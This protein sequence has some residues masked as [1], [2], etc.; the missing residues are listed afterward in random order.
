MQTLPG[1][2]A[3][4]NVLYRLDKEMCQHFGKFPEECNHLDLWLMNQPK[5]TIT[6]L[7]TIIKITNLGI[8]ITITYIRIIITFTYVR[9]IITIT[10]VHIIIK[11]A[12]YV[13][14]LKL[15]LTKYTIK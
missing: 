7:R 12:Y 14:Q 11:I 5:S 9:I 8:I 4:L 13:L 15:N 1:K 3:A 10:Y 2:F 6:Y